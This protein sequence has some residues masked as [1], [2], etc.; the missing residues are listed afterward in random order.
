M[1]PAEIGVL[2]TVLP[3]NLRTR[4][5]QVRHRGTN[6]ILPGGFETRL[7]RKRFKVQVKCSDDVVYLAYFPISQVVP[8]TRPI[9]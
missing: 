9:D 5:N 8:D 3:F 1:L 2:Q 7:R 4:N 6:H